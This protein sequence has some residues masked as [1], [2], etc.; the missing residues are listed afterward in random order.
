MGVIIILSFIILIIIYNLYNCNKRLR[1]NLRIKS[2]E[3]EVIK[4]VG[5][6]YGEKYEERSTNCE[7]IKDKYSFDDR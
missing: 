6:E 4:A 5:G 1:K 7:I 3:A 2:A